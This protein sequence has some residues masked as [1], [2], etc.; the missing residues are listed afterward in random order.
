MTDQETRIK[1]KVQARKMAREIRYLLEWEDGTGA[2]YAEAFLNEMKQLLPCR[3][4]P[5]PEK[6]KWNYAQLAATR[7]PFGETWIG[8]RFD[9][10]D[11]SALKWLC[12]AQE[13]FYPKL[14]AFLTHPQRPEE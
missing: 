12:K 3:T 14:R 11:P 4:P 7:M 13:E 6:P 2:D 9:E 5:K 1:A 8:K 10:M